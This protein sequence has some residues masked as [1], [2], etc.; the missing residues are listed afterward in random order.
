MYI[1]Y[2]KLLV[3]TELSEWDSIMP[4]FQLQMSPA[5]LQVCKSIYDEAVSVLYG[6]NTFIFDATHVCSVWECPSY[7]ASII[8]PIA[9]TSYFSR[10]SPI[11]DRLELLPAF[12]KVQ[13]WKVAV[14]LV[15]QHEP[16]DSLPKVLANF[17]QSL[18]GH[19]SVV[20]VEIAM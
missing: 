18:H 8:S 19:S 9:R 3:P 14:S 11:V 10:K 16:H 15:Q 1:I 7:G 20:F 17:C 6:S 5:V 2:E 13:R 4:R 12:R